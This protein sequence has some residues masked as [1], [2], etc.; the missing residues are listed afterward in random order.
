MIPAPRQNTEFTSFEWQ[1]WFFRVQ[2]QVQA[3]TNE[4]I[5]TT[6]FSLT[7][8]NGFRQYNLILNPAGV[9]A[10]GT[11]IFPTNP[12]QGDVVSLLSTQNVTA[13]TIIVPSGITATGS[14]TSLTANA[15]VKFVFS[16]TT[17]YKH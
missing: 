13:L 4:V 17:W 2:N 3:F 7:I 5:P 16:G 10:T 6:G 8:N 12:V 11:V 15:S 14:V 9:L 1:D